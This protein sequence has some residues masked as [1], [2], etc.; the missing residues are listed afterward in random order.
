MHYSFLALGDS[1][2][3]GEQVVLAQSFP[4]QTVQMLREKKLHFYAPEIIATT[5]HT[6]EELENAINET[7]TL[8]NYSVVCLLIGVNNQYE[9]ISVAVFELSFEKLM[10]KA[11]EFAGNN[12]THVFILSIPDWGI[13]PFAADRDIQKIASEINAYNLVCKT[14]AEKYGANF[15]DI[16]ASQRADSGKEGFL[17]ADK[18]HPGEKEYAKWAEMLCQKIIEQLG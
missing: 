8:H 14:M 13:T 15:I 3:I 6:I 16:T 18:L 12:P 11:V 9:G 7:I 10:L 2:T 1:Y 5:G 17:V 4:Y